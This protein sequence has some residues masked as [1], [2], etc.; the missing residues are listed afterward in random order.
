MRHLVL[1]M[2]LL[3]PALFGAAASRLAP[4]LPPRQA[5]WLLSAG[6]AVAALSATFVLFALAFV[7][8]GQ[9][10]EVAE[11]GQWSVAVLRA[12][13]PVDV[14]LETAALVA[15]VTVA[16]L[17]MAAA[18]GRALAVRAAYRS[19]RELPAGTGE[20]VVVPSADAVAWAVPGR[21]G[22]IVIAAPLL[23]ALS[24]EQRRAVL[25]HE[26]AHLEHGHHWHLAAVTLA[27]AVNPLLI[28]LRRAAAQ[29]AERW[30]DE[31]AAAELGDRRM[32]ASALGSAAMLGRA[33]PSSPSLAATAGSVPLRVAALLAPS[34]RARPVMLT[35]ITLL[36][37]VGVACALLAEKEI[38][39][40]FEFAR[41]AAAR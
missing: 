34:P 10:P 33:R 39:H 18:V 3:V 8:V 29:A 26:R 14:P 13:S 11:A 20:L 9:E 25:A 1:V 30:A 28:G 15:A 6:A 32:V 7:L 36:L 22:R 35:L 38:E 17:A 16:G 12:R 24:P 31:E 23:E 41:H 37:V 5:T 40:L 2:P 27:T 21:P 4:L 19:C